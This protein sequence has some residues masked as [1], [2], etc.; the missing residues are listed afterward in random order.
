MTA[1]SVYQAVLNVPVR[2]TPDHLYV[3]AAAEHGELVFSEIGCASC[4]VPSLPL[5]NEGWIYSEPNP[6]NPPGTLQVGQVEAL[7]VDLSDPSLPGERLQP[8]NGIVWVP[9]FTDLKLHDITDGPD[10]PNA[11]PLDM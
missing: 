5:D 8:V 11:E 10:D 7:Y 4:H 6:Y 1:A 9:A 3:R 2:V